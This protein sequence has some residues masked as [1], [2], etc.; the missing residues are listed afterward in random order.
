MKSLKKQVDEQVNGSNI[1]TNGWYNCNFIY[2]PFIKFTL[3]SIIYIKL[4][5]CFRATLRL[6]QHNYKLRINNF[7]FIIH[8]KLFLHLF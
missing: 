7:F 2:E 4:S 1:E 5:N 6:V 8:S 3:S